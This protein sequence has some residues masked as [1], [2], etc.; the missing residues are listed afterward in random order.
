MNTHPAIALLKKGLDLSTNEG[1]RL[2]VT[3]AQNLTADSTLAPG[4]HELSLLDQFV[5]GQLTIEQVLEQLEK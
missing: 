1:R 2:L 5:L 4:P 3:R